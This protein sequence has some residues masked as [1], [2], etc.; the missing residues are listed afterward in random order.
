MKRNKIYLNNFYF[1]F[2][3]ILFTYEYENNLTV[4][5]CWLW[6]H[7][8]NGNIKIYYSHS[9]VTLTLFKCNICNLFLLFY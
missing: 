3:S 9:V 8:L 5:S 7:L 1:N 4:I 6:I 2:I